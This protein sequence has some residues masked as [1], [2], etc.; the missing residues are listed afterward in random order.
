M[1]KSIFLSTLMLISMAASAD[2][3]AQN[4]HEVVA[5]LQNFINELPGDISGAGED[6]KEIFADFSEN[7]K[8]FFSPVIEK[9]LITYYEAG[10][11]LDGAY[12]RTKEDLAD[13]AEELQDAGT[14]IKNSAA[15]YI[16]SLKKIPQAVNNWLK[17]RGI[18]ISNT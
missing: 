18:T 2:E 17:A 4:P 6:A 10:V 13:V 5:S 1:K 15:P 9:F 12:T 16:A 7:T 3:P 14:S 8:Q 11:Y